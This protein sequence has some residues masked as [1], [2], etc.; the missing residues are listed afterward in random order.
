MCIRDSLS[1]GWALS[2]A[3]ALRIT[4]RERGIHPRGSSDWISWMRTFWKS[5]NRDRFTSNMNLDRLLH[6][7]FR[8][9]DGLMQ[10]KN[11]YFT[12]IFQCCFNKIWGFRSQIIAIEG[13]CVYLNCCSTSGIIVWQSAHL[14]VANTSSGWTGCVLTTWPVIR[15]SFPIRAEVNSRTFISLSTSLKAT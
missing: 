11:V 5:T 3:S 12:C 1:P 10:R 8:H 2:T 14:N 15:K 6:T 13:T 9:I 7:G 4:S